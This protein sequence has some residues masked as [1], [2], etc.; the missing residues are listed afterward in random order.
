MGFDA[1]EETVSQSGGWDVR[2]RAIFARDCRNERAN[3]LQKHPAVKK[4]KLVPVC[5]D[6]WKAKRLPICEIISSLE[7]EA[8]V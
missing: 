2:K 8:T 6:E 5:N 4:K 1:G 7:K 3:Q